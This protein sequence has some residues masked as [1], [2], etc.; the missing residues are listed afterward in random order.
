MNIGTYTLCMSR[1]VEYRAAVFIMLAAILACVAILLVPGLFE[2]FRTGRL[3]TI[4]VLLVGTAS[5]AALAK[6]NRDQ[7]AE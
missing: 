2:N 6:R 3:L 7:L 4:L 1:A 5:F